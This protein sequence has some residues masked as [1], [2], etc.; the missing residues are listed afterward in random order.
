MSVR[1]LERNTRIFCRRTEP[2][3]PAQF[4]GE[5]PPFR[6]KLDDKTIARVI[7][8]REAGAAI[9]KELEMTQA[10]AKHTYDMFYHQKG[11]EVVNALQN[12]AETKQ[13]K[14][15]FGIVISETKNRPKHNMIGW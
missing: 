5:M 3:I 4:A 12:K 15:Q 9:A 7:E 8:M 2:G 11:M 14:M 6:D 10:K 13:E 1:I